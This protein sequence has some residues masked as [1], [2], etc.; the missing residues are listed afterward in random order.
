MVVTLLSTTPRHSY[1]SSA[2]GSG[3]MTV[4]EVV[5]DTNL[6]ACLASAYIVFMGIACDVNSMTVLLL[7]RVVTAI[8]NFHTLRLPPAIQRPINILTS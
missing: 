3:V 8:F 5:H 2:D 6:T 7:Q 1:K 4:T